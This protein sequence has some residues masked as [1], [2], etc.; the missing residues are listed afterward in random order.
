M[1]DSWNREMIKVIVLKVSC[2]WGGFEKV[3]FGI[4]V[5]GF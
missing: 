5:V 2:G 3:N 1:E 4:I